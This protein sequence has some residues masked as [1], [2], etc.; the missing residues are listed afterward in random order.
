M[1][2]PCSQLHPRRLSPS[3]LKPP[4]TGLSLLRLLANND[5]AG[6]HTLLE[7]LA[8]KNSEQAYSIAWC[9]VLTQ[10]PSAH[11]QAS[12]T[13]TPTHTSSIPST[14]S[15]GS[16]KAPIPE[17]GQPAHRRPCPN[18]ASSSTSSSSPSATKSHRAAKRPTRHCPCAMPQSCSSSRTVKISWTLRIAGQ[19][20]RSTLRLR[21]SNFKGQGPR[22]SRQGRIYPRN[23][24]LKT[25]YH[26]QKN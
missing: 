20:G 8:A 14:S 3:K 10:P 25:S 13:C 15:D 9:T 5:I 6:F 12:K 22:K 17:Y 11:P 18:T 2:S 26:T 16:W 1:L 19:G 21:L 23:A 7:E 24:S 4:L